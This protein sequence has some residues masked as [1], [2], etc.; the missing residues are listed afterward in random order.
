MGFGVAARV[1]DPSIHCQGLLKRRKNCRELVF[2]D[3]EY[4]VKYLFLNSLC[5]LFKAGGL[6]SNFMVR[7]SG[8]GVLVLSC[9]QANQAGMEEGN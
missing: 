8:T 4:S 3:G 7:V 2:F 1:L 5:R 9:G 6:K